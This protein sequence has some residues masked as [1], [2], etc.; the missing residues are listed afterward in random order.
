[1]SSKETIYDAFKKPKN[2]ISPPISEWEFGVGNIPA[3]YPY[4]FKPE[5]L[6]NFPKKNSYESQQQGSS[7]KIDNDLISE[8]RE[9]SKNIIRTPSSPEDFSLLADTTPSRNKILYN[10]STFASSHQ[11]QIDSTLRS[12]TS[13]SSYTGHHHINDR[14]YSISALRRPSQIILSKYDEN[15]EIG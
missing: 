4:S 10:N 3:P 5:D 6:G 2:L 7:N 11:S 9:M 12:R 13:S 1:M 14:P 8:Q 15:V